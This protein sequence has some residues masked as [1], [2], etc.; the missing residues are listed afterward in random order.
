MKKAIVNSV[1]TAMSMVLMTGV[2]VG[3]LPGCVSHDYVGET[4]APTQHVQVF[5]DDAVPAGYR[6]M[7]QDR[8]DSID[9]TST[10]DIVQDMVEK[11]REV[12]A[13]AILITSVE[14]VETGSSTTTQGKDKEK[15][16]EWR[17]NAHTTVIREKVVTAK[18]LKRI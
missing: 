17:S 8:A 5:F 7:G 2:L 11:A 9:A 12:G 16:G 4:Y 13:D 18:F 1:L 3:L 10:Q 14:S 6:V 15:D